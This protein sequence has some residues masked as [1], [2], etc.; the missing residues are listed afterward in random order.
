[1]ENAKRETQLHCESHP[2]GGGGAQRRAN[3]VIVCSNRGTD[4]NSCETTVVSSRHYRRVVLWA[5]EDTVN[6]VPSPVK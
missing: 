4:T 6:S 5:H 2:S 1:M 3:E